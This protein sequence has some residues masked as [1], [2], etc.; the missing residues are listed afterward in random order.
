MPSWCNNVD[1]VLLSMSRIQKDKRSRIK[2]MY[3]TLDNIQ[4]EMKREEEKYM[5]ELKREE[6]EL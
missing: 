1:R 3:K 5:G 4:G 6:K 2:N